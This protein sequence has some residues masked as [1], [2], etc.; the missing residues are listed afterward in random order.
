MHVHIDASSR[1][2]I[3]QGITLLTHLLEEL[4][5][6]SKDGKDAELDASASI[7]PS[8]SAPSL[9]LEVLRLLDSSTAGS[10]TSYQVAAA[11]GM[12]QPTYAAKIRGTGKAATQAQDTLYLRNWT[13]EGGK[14]VRVYTITDEGRRIAQLLEQSA[15]SAVPFGIKDR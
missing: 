9:Q 14:R 8:L 2:D 15:K 12:T 7:P 6:T 3:A 5:K 10:L 4:S 11:L 13:F 1:A